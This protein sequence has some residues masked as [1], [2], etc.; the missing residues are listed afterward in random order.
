MSIKEELSSPDR[1]IEEELTALARNV[2]GAFDACDL[3]KCKRALGEYFSLIRYAHAFGLLSTEDMEDKIAHWSG[4]M[5]LLAQSSPS[6]AFFTAYEAMQICMRNENGLVPCDPLIA[7]AVFTHIN[8]YVTPA[9][10]SHVAVGLQRHMVFD[11]VPVTSRENYTMDQ[12]KRYLIPL[13]NV[14]TGTSQILNSQH[15]QD[16]FFEALTH[17]ENL[18]YSSL[19]HPLD[20]FEAVKELHDWAEK[21]HKHGAL[22]TRTRELMDDATYLPDGRGMIRHALEIQADELARESREFYA[23]QTVDIT[24]AFAVKAGVDPAL[25]KI[26]QKI[27]RALADGRAK[28]AENALTNLFFELGQDGEDA[29]GNVT[30]DLKSYKYFFDAANRLAGMSITNASRL[31]HRCIAAMEEDISVSELVMAGVH[32]YALLAMAGVNIAESQYARTAMG[33][34]KTIMKWSSEFEEVE[35]ADEIL[36]CATG[37]YEQCL[38]TLGPTERYDEI[39][40]LIAWVD[41]CEY[42]TP[43]LQGFTHRMMS[44]VVAYGNKKGIRFACDTPEPDLQLVPR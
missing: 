39:A 36:D 21:N 6:F 10:Y 28:D 11:G 24:K 15:F 37:G 18:I 20:S 31:G 29:D 9:I 16:T 4:G 35:N 12:A 1:N 19:V 7:N 44:D 17:F 3:G 33:I 32:E 13:M 22:A 30:E 25:S 42:P 14:L 23:N 43:Y 5:I 41:D 26:H 8:V 2:Q 27:E 34:Y 38:M 40:E